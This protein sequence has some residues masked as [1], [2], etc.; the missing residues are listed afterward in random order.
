MI[1][2]IVSVFQ[3]L[4]SIYSIHSENYHNNVLFI[5]EH[6]QGENT[7]KLSINQFITMKPIM[8]NPLYQFT[9]GT[10]NGSLSE[11]LVP[12]SIDW[13]ERGIITNVKNQ[14]KCGSCWAFS[15]TGAIESV[16][17]IDTGELKN[18]SEQQL[19]DCSQDYGNNGCQ[20]GLMDNAF[21]Y[22]ISNGICSEDEYPYTGERGMCQPCNT[23]IT[24]DDYKDVIP[25]SEY[26]LKRVVAQQPV[27][28]AIQANLRSFQF[29]SSGIYSDPMCG[30]KLDH[31]ILIV[32][33]GYDEQY[34]LDYWIIKNSWGPHWGE[35]GYIRI[36][37]NIENR[38]GL[39]GIT[40]QPSIPL[41]TD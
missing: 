4:A 33:Y 8:E 27:S 30:N 32:G 35:N 38:S 22:V 21:K 17:A 10:Y 13:R 28:A 16:N 37:R 6:N 23:T 11:E 39:C 2:L 3:F 18:V 40:L 14:G 29:Y 26:I 34:D 31:G 5:K 9:N 24:I 15:A 7:Y 19:M 36:Q 25:N 20:G 12:E 41:I 1:R